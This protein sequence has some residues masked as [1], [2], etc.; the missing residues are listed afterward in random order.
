MKKIL[1]LFVVAFSLMSFTSSEYIIK[2]NS[3]D[4]V[5]EFEVINDYE[6]SVEYSYSDEID[7]WTCTLTIVFSDFTTTTIVGE[8]CISAEMACFYARRELSRRLD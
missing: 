6:I 2:N 3:E 7:C 8:S 5:T 4:I 1:I